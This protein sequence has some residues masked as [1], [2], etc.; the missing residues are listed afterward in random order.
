MTHEEIKNSIY[1]YSLDALD[2]VERKIL[3]QH[4]A[5]GCPECETLLAEMRDI[6]ALMPYAAEEVAPPAQVK[7]NLMAAIQ[8]AAQAAAPA[9]LAETTTETKASLPEGLEKLVQKWRRLSIGFAGGLGFAVVVLFVVIGVFRNQLSE[10]ERRLEISDALVQ[11][12]Q[13]TQNELDKILKIVHAPK[14]KVFDLNGLEPSPNSKGRVFLDEDSKEAVFY[15]Y[16]LPQTPTGKDYQL[17][18]LRGSQPI[19]AGVFALNPD[20]T[21]EVRLQNIENIDQLS[22]FAVTL[23]DQGGV[24]QPLGAMYLLGVVS[25]GG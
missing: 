21:A 10:M 17:W 7:T 16:N 6:S 19:D 20:G 22:G 13:T 8:G 25:A 1:A 24:P 5:Q 2:S 4:L 14:F 11:E 9:P 23:E 18:M 3:E 12:L 15:V